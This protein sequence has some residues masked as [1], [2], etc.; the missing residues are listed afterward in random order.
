MQHRGAGRDFWQKDKDT[1][2]VSWFAGGSSKHLRAGGTQDGARVCRRCKEVRR[3]RGGAREIWQSAGNSEAAFA[4]LGPA[5][6]AFIRA[7]V[8]GGW[9]QPTCV[10]VTRTGAGGVRSGVS[11]WGGEA[12][13]RGDERVS[14][15]EVRELQAVRGGSVGAR[16]CVCVCVCVH[17]RREHPAWGG[18]GAR[19]GQ[20]SRV[21]AAWLRPP[22]A[23]S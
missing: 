23:T 20:R 9:G 5:R 18:R 15:W 16:V 22:H 7:R 10:W 13:V 11:A 2:A 14:A 1:A 12:C 19:G 8:G 3:A 17:G 4:Y 6:F 21:A